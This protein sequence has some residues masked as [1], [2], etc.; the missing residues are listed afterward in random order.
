VA[1]A[2]AF[3]FRPQLAT[4][5]KWDKWTDTPLPPEEPAGQNPP[6]GAILDYYL[7]GSVAGPVTL[8]I[9]DPAGKSVRKYSSEDPPEQPVEGR[10]IPDYWIR[11]P[12]VLSADAGMHR[13]VWDLHYPPP[14]VLQY[15]YPISAIY[16]NTPR[17]P[18]GPWVSPG[19]YTVKLTVNGKVH[20]QPL[21]V[22]MDPRIKAAPAVLAR[23]FVL[24]ST[25]YDGIRKD[26]DA[27]RELRAMRAQLG[28][29]KERA[30]PGAV[31]DSITA[32]DRKAAALEGGGGGPGGGGGRRAGG[33]TPETLV[34]V[35]GTLV[36]VLNL[37]QGADVAPTTQALAAV[38]EAGRG[39]RNVMERWNA[40]RSKEVS[41]LNVQLR[42][43]NLPPVDP[44]S[45]KAAR[46]DMGEE[47]VIAGEDE[48]EE[49]P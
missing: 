10:N 26:Y 35:N 45:W 29:L 48:Q 28:K 25:M 22:R 37:L 32:L 6:D 20:T 23:Q 31:A 8:E 34:E 4:R 3:L 9:T 49:E 15:T 5:F 11:P 39:L 42:E 7:N 13:F 43:A 19:R 36:S 17:L 47:E 38:T 27:L 46:V 14:A 40:I 41:Q 33:E 21:T 44:T 1:Q 24:S 2:D 18:L 30:G 12:Q 16:R